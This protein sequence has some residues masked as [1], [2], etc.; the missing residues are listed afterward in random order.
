MSLPPPGAKKPAALPPAKLAPM[1]PA[2]AVGAASGKKFSASAPEKRNNQRVAIYGNGGMGKTSLALRAPGPVVVIDLDGSVD[3]I[4]DSLPHDLPV[5]VLRGVDT[6]QDLRDCL[7]Q[8]DL[9]DGIQT[10]VLDTASKAE[11]LCVAHILANVRTEK[12][13]KCERLEDYGFGKGYRHVYEEFLKLFGDL[14]VHYNQGRNIIIVAHEAT[15]K[16]PNPAGEDF[17]RFE[18]RLQNSDKSNLRSKLREWVDHLIFISL[19]IFAKDGKVQGGGSRTLYP[20]E[21]GHFQ[22]KSRLLSAPIPYPAGD[23]ALWQAIFSPA[24][25]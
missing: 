8:A 13:M 22:A 18:P 24:P 9:W 20:T 10:V 21:Q 1:A 16:I 6:W 7:H 19:D 25:F 11:E 3:V 5:K 2:A 23:T 12:G 15:S 17:L 4:K 14:E